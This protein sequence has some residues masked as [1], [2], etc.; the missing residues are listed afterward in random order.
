[1]TKFKINDKVLVLISQNITTVLEVKEV[2]DYYGKRSGYVLKDRPIDLL[3]TDGEL[4]LIIEEEPS[5]Q[6]IVPVQAEKTV[7]KNKNKNVEKTSS[8]KHTNTDFEIGAALST[9]M[10]I[11]TEEPDVTRTYDDYCSNNS[12]NESYSSYDSSSYDSGSSSSCD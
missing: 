10:I 2:D 1:M 6:P 11:G 5:I 4:S 8:T 9:Y 7:Q 12:S 3:Y